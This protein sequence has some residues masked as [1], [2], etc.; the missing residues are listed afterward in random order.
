[1]GLDV[2]RKTLDRKSGEERDFYA[3]GVV[4]RYVA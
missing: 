1:M 3:T 4:M 2:I